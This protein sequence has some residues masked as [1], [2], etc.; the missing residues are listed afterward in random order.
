MLTDSHAHLTDKRLQKDIVAVLARAKAVGVDTIINVGCDLPSA[1]IAVEQA[2][3]YEGVYAA[4]G[5]HPHDAKDADER[6]WEVLRRLALQP[7]V[8]A[9]GEMGFDFYYNHSPRKV[10]E[11]VFRRQLNLARQLHLPVIIHD[12][13][14]HE[15]TFAVLRDEKAADVGGVLHC[16]SGDVAFAKKCLDLGFYLSFAG[17]ITFKNPGA[18]PEVARM[19]PLDRILVETDSPY[20]A[21]VPYRGKRNEPAFVKEV[22]LK[23]ADLRGLAFADFARTVSENARTLFALDKFDR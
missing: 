3:K 17:S 21:P 22:A 4:V 18:L 14:A 16:F 2:A 19:V 9:L 23:I 7:K 20:L 8:V 10:Q 5:I 15:E 12:R 11:E 1:Q 6:T 13:E